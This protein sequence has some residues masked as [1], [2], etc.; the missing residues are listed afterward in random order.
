LLTLS[1]SS[2]FLS[3]RT[4]L[5]APGYLRLAQAMRRPARRPPG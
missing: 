3:E 4:V 2:P 1:H 5:L